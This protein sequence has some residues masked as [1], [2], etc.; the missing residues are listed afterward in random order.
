MSNDDKDTVDVQLEFSVKSHRD[1][2]TA[3]FRFDRFDQVF[4]VTPKIYQNYLQI[5]FVARYTVEEYDNPD[6]KFRGGQALVKN[7]EFNAATRSHTNGIYLEA[8]KEYKIILSILSSKTRL[9]EYKSI[10]VD[11]T[12]YEGAY[13][14]SK[15]AQTVYPVAGGGSRRSKRS[16]RAK[17]SK[18]FKRTRRSKRLH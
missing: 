11:N 4:I 2:K 9:F 16:K 14:P 18:R 12:K 6:K 7:I 3:V 1:G 8:G 17:R 5:L 13:D 10:S 15:N